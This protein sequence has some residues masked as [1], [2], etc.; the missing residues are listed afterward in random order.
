VSWGG[1]KIL[2]R[3]D[4]TSGALIVI[5]L[6]SSRLGPAS[7]GTRMKRYPDREDARQDAM[8]LS[9]G[10]TYKWAAAGFPRGGGKA[11]IAVPPELDAAARDALLRRYG[12]FIQEL[13]GRFW[14]GADVGTSARDMDVI[15]ETG[16]PYVFSRTPEHGGAGDSG[17]WTALSVF[18]SI[19]ATCARI[20]GG[21]SVAGRRVLVQGT[22]S[23]GG[24]LIGML[25]AAGASVS[26]SD[27]L[28]SAVARYRDGLGLPFVPPEA[29]FDA[30]CDVFAPCALGGVLDVRTI[31][32]LTCRAVVGAAN[33]QLSTPED[34]S[35]LR[36]RGILY[37][38]DFVVNAGGAIAITGQE[39]L[40][41]SKE[42]AR[43]EVLR[44]GSTLSRIFDL[45]EAEGITPDA[46]AR[47]IAETRLR[48]AG[49]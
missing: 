24:G 47:R 45:A 16:A 6:H 36:E 28:P 37:A 26:F 32:R 33:N 31:P 7:G 48:G 15:A 11:V 27:V 43:E 18:T 38:P 1:E 23:V 42:R 22:G 29:V 14:T 9:E 10:M 13:S 2:E 44:I 5:A 3:E 40:G 8:R 35:R 17:P 4:A 46:A 12:S 41:W 39:A 49:P 21:L 19:E 34:A 30:P 25:T 20:F